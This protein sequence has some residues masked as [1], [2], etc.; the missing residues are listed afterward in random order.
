MFGFYTSIIRTET[1]EQGLITDRINKATEGL[2]KNDE[3]GK[4]IIEVRLGALYSLERIAQDSI[5]DHMQIIKIL[6]AYARHNGGLQ[7]KAEKPREDVIAAVTIIG[8]RDRW[9]NGRRLIRRESLE[10]YHLDLRDCDLRNINIYRANLSNALLDGADLRGAELQSIELLHA[11]LKNADLRGAKLFS[12]NIKYTRFD[13][14]DL[15]DAKFGNANLENAGFTGTIMIKTDFSNANMTKAYIVNANMSN[16]RFS[17]TKFNQAWFEKTNMTGANFHNTDFTNA[18][19][20]YG[21]M[22][23]AQFINANL[24]KTNLNGISMSGINFQG[25]NMMNARFNYHPDTCESYAY[26]G[27]FS[28]CKNFIQEQL[29]QFFFGIRVKIPDGLTRPDHW[30]K[31]DIT[32]DEFV[33]ALKE[34]IKNR[35]IKTELEIKRQHELKIKTRQ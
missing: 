22:D 35:E 16:A 14:A 15:S 5:R 9:P 27:D 10:A 7:D 12:G 24:N 8:Q 3:N 33:K 29:N 6:C 11:T 28:K 20:L 26:T 25:S 32:F 34:M 21:N 1:Q 18:H 19:F 17:F 4:P 13:K 31:N 2:G 30:P 23:N